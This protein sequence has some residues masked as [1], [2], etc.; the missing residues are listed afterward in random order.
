M[1]SNRF[2]IGSVAM[3]DGYRLKVGLGVRVPQPHRLRRGVER[4]GTEQADVG[5]AEDGAS[6][7][8]CGG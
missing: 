7:R 3:Q 8:G 2:D 6:Q 1:P 5:R 4:S